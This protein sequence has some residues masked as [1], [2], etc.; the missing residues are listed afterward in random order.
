M[1]NRIRSYLLVLTLF[2]ILTGCQNA[3]LPSINTNTQNKT[4]PM[5]TPATGK[6]VMYGQ[7][8][9]SKDGKPFVN[10]PVRLAQIYRKGDQGAFVLDMANSPSSL[11][12]ADGNFTIINI[13]PAEY[14]LV[15]GKP[16]D[17]NYV[18]YQDKNGKPNT[19]QITAN[20]TVKVGTLRV[21]YTP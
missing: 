20:Q 15:I 5:P 8:L 19:Y 12:D 2:W 18:L 7:A 1:K 17:N 14:L 10:T 11:T 6:A 21:D 16:E 9:S 4:K 3:A 13:N